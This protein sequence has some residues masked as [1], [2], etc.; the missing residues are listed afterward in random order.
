MLSTSLSQKEF[1]KSERFSSK[2]FSKPAFKSS[3]TKSFAS[4]TIDPSSGRLNKQTLNIKSNNILQTY[5]WR[6]KDVNLK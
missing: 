4:S 1:I 6:K 5:L 3:Q 2:E